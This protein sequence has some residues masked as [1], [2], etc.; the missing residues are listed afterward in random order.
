MWLGLWNGAD[1]LHFTRTYWEKV[2]RAFIRRCPPRGKC[3]LTFPVHLQWLNNYFPPGVFADC[4]AVLGLGVFWQ[5][6]ASTRSCLACCWKEYA[7]LHCEEQ[8]LRHP[9]FHNS[10]WQNSSKR[11]LHT[12]YAIL[13]ILSSFY[14]PCP[15]NFKHCWLIF[16]P[17]FWWSF[18]FFSSLKQ[19]P[20]ITSFYS[21]MHF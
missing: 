5:W 15:G 9:S 12:L 21:S 8:R 20:E 11:S 18:F 3:K 16:I 14:I 2:C 17:V 13:Y 4:F 1:S 7:S 10:S 19:T 6:V